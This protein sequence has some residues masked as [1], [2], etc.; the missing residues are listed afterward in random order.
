MRNRGD[1][2]MRHETKFS[3]VPIYSDAIVM[4]LKCTRNPV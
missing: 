1:K 4:V 3:A 2:D